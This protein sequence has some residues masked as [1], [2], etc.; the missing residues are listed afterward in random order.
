MTRRVVC[1]SCGAK[2][3]QTL[4]KCPY[5]DT[6]NY[7]GAEAEYMHKLQKLRGE[8]EDLGNVPEQETRNELQKQKQ[9]VKR[10]LLVLL[11]IAAVVTGIAGV[12]RIISELSERDS[13][14]DSIWQKETF[15]VF[16]ELYKQEDYETLLELFT[17]SSEERKPV[18]AW[19]HSYFCIELQNCQEINGLLDQEKEGKALEKYEET[20]LLNS[21]WCLRGIDYRA[22]LSENEKERLQPYIDKCM[23]RLDSRWDFSEEE[24]AE[25]EQQ[26]RNN[27]GIMPYD[28]CAEYI[29][30]WMKGKA[31]SEM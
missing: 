14:A 27:Y 7:K 23:D 11:V 10:I 12:K 25:F 18:Y 24:Q 21:Y 22:M 1:N 6:M 17:Q 13:K 28:F 15:P 31:D 26:M 4:S 3:K 20:S 19:K 29:E 2:F 9:K 16:D 8:V 5:C 30:Q